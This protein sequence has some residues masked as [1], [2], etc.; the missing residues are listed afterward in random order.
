MRRVRSLASSRDKIHQHDFLTHGIN[1]PWGFMLPASLA[2]GNTLTLFL[3]A[4]VPA[5]RAVGS[6]NKTLASKP[7]PVVNFSG[8]TNLFNQS[9]D[10][11]ASSAN[12]VDLTASISLDVGA[13][14]DVTV[15]LGADAAGSLIPPHIAEF[16]LTFGV[17]YCVLGTTKID[18]F[19][20][21]CVALDGNVGANLSVV[22][23]VTGQI[24]SPS[25]ILFQTGFP[26]LSIP[27]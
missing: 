23:N 1:G 18:K 5:P 9:I 8:V 14:V 11:P 7:I 19:D 24:S 20:D 21:L 12:P 15:S 10:C 6:F 26:G 16:G 25:F 22:A 13:D 17:S 4:R 2:R 27:G 3:H